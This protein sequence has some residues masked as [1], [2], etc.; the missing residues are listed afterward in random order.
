MSPE[1]LIGIGAALALLYGT[2]V[3]RAKALWR[4]AVKTGAVLALAMAAIAGDAPMAL[5]IALV[6]SA[7]GDWA[8]ARPGKDRLAQG[9]ISFGIAHLCY[10][11]LIFLHYG[12][13]GANLMRWTALV[14]LLVFGGGMARLLWPRAGAVRG[15]V[16]AYLG[17]ILFLGVFALG[18]PGKLWVAILAAALFILSDTLLALELFVLKD[19]VVRRAA[20]LTVWP[21]YWLAQAG[22]LLAFLSA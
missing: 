21:V 11:V 17:V 3:G 14:A 8:L 19:A 18:L 22:F 4:A 10:I 16:M 6:L 9:M 2:Q 13:D 12:P 7:S 1:A 5:A 20:A 15:A